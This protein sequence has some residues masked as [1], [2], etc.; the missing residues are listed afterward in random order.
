MFRPV[1]LKTLGSA[2]VVVALLCA[3]IYYYVQWGNKR[4]MAEIGQPPRS[5]TE[6][7]LGAEVQSSDTQT[8]IEP[9]EFVSDNNVAS[10]SEFV[11]EPEPMDKETS[12]PITGT[13]ETTSEMT[14][15]FDPTPLL[16][17][18]GLPE[19][20][21]SVFDAEAEVEDIEVAETHIVETYG[22]SPEVE[23]VVDR[24]KQLS[25]GPVE[26][27]DL[28]ELFE[29]WIQVLPEEDQAS[30]R[31]L[32]NVLT[33]INQIG[34]NGGNLPVNMEIRVIDANAFGD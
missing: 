19:E 27:G 10:E 21:T 22:Q 1:K 6:P 30:R 13:S 11:E 26:L 29:A 8:F 34:M 5:T 9:V 32:M 7:E 28:T 31:Q 23:E 12:V 25:G 14:P 4:F 24:L 20:V 16:S 3:G 33:Q 17:V 15:E 2:C 18:F